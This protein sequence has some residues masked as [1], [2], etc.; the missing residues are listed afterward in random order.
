[1][2]TLAMLKIPPEVQLSI[3][4]GDLTQVHV[5][6]IVN[7]AN[8]HLNH[9]GGVAGAIVRRG[10]DS[11][12]QESDDWVRAHGPIRSDRPAITSAG[13]LHCRFVIHAVGPVWGEGEEDAKLHA[14]V[15]HALALADQHSLQSIALPAI[16]TG[17]YRFPVRRAANLILK[18]ILKFLEE[19]PMC[20]LRQIL[21]VLLDSN[22][23][24][25]FQE[26]LSDLDPKLKA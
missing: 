23:A 13:R 22:T 5:D 17:I 3:V 15:V 8:A 7:A 1:M 11:I 24:G 21:V 25:L 6:A 16:S 2:Q 20:S 18:A 14:A 26:V 4:Q 12:Q 10:G 19:H 9:G